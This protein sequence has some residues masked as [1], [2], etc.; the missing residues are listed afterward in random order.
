MTDQQWKRALELYETASELPGPAARALLDSG[1]EEPAVVQK[2]NRLLGSAGFFKEHAQDGPLADSPTARYAGSII[3]RYDV[4]DLLGRGSTGEVYAGRDRELGRPVSLKIMSA[5]FAALHSSSQRF[6]RE[7]QAS[8]ALNHPNIVTVHEVITWN[9]YPVIVMERVEGKSLR[10]LCG[11]PIPVATAVPVAAQIMRALATAHAHGIV[12]RDLKPEN[13]IVRPDGYVKVLD[14]G[15]ARLSFLEGNGGEG[16][17]TEGLPVGTLRYMSPEQCRGEAATP[18]SDVFA[19]GIVLYEMLAGRHPFYADS[20]LETAHAIAWIEPRPLQQANPELS[21]TF[22]LLVTRMLGKDPVARPSAHE[23]AETLT[24]AP[25]WP[26]QT[27]RWRGRLLFSFAALIAVLA[28]AAGAFWFTKGSRPTTPAD[29]LQE[30]DIRI[31]PVASLLGLERMPDLSPDGNRVVFEFSNESSPISH[32][33][34]K[35]RLTARL[36]QLTDAAWPDTQPVFSPDGSKLAFL[37]RQNRQTHVMLM[38][39]SGGIERKLAEISDTGI[40]QRT[41]SWDGPGTNVIVSEGLAGTRA[42]AALFAISV[43][44][45][46]KRQITFPGAGELDCMPVVSPD[47]R[48]LGF[49]RVNDR[50]IGL[51][52]TLPVRSGLPV[53]DE[54]QKRPLTQT[55][56]SIACWNW[57][58][59]GHDLLMCRVKAGRKLLWRYPLLSGSPSRVAGLDEEVTETTVSRLANHIIYSGEP[60][61]N[62]S[63]WQYSVPP[64]SGTPK[65]LIASA[66]MDVDAR[67]SPDGKNIAFASSRAAEGQT[68]LWI[69]ASDG[70][71]Q[72]QLTSGEDQLPHT[73]GSPSWSPDGRWIAYDANFHEPKTGI[74]VLDVLG[75]NPRRLT[76]PDASGS[77]PSWSRD[78]QWIYYSSDRGAGQNIWKVSPAGGAP[79]QVTHDSGFESFESPDSKFLYFSP[80]GSR[81]GGIWRMPLPDGQAEPVTGLEGVTDR[82]W[83]GSFKGIY[84]TLP[85]KPP[86][87]ELYNFSTRQVTHIRPVQTPPPGIY[88]GISVSPDGLSML[89]LQVDPGR[90]NIMIASNFH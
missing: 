24:V 19:A 11:K 71:N 79:V 9:S 40:G 26:P 41:I 86:A 33:Y 78:G 6:L 58:P 37:R 83:E 69:C 62:M 73:A 27:A 81:S 68:D 61:Q 60:T 1:S 12:H 22:Q 7:A 15:L 82:N 32:I 28:V 43:D 70:S 56:E 89:Y 57:T 4:I 85:L 10:A 84:F 72:R 66:K 74:Y 52:W 44:S 3:G 45:G 50:S 17:S 90:S 48:S 88:H 2:V 49:A 55:A 77:V 18:A 59:D 29:S 31:V 38:P 23:V 39:S 76:S 30:S 64:A 63:I 46:A 80:Y 65:R 13:V 16:S 54:N 67:Y 25:D 47:R 75:G 51:I 34:L 35:D 5:E 87:L 14:F 36:T 8:S 20:P 53:A 21:S 42:H